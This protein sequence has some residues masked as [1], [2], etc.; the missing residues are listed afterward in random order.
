M[1][2]HRFLTFIALFVLLGMSLAACDRTVTRVEQ[3]AAK[4]D[5]CFDCHND[6]NTIL[7]AAHQQWA[8]SLHA[9]GHNT[10]RNESPCSGCHTREGF[11]AIAQGGIPGD[12]PNAT[13]IHCFTC[14]A[15]HTNSLG[16][17][18]GGGFALRIEDP[19]T[20]RDGFTFDIGAGNICAACHNALEDV[21]TF[22]RTANDTV[23]FPRHTHWGPHHSVQADNFFGSNGY[24]YT[25]FAYEQTNHK[26]AVTDGCLQCHYVVTQNFVVGGHSFNMKGTISTHDGDEEVVNQDACL[27]CHNLDGAD[28]D[29]FDHN[30]RQTEITALSDS[31][32]TILENAGLL[33]NQHNVPNVVTSSDSAGAVWNWLMVHEDRSV[34]VHNFK[35]MRS[36]L[37]SSIMFME[38]DLPQASPAP[39][40][41]SGAIRNRHAAPSE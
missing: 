8:N 6:Q 31:L 18:S 39:V 36:L 2:P 35:W 41:S 33:A 16:G 24:E 5:N 37:K 7:I 12:Y 9:S 25:G 19:Q 21:N 15:P 23:T 14:H 26:S 28:V 40:A 10:D 4:A 1:K 22:V 32:E 20:L 34:G 3:T 27:P 11:V 38:G 17:L 30:G 13:M 29:G